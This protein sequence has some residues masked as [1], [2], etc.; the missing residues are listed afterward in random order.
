M[1][2]IGT[3]GYS[4]PDWKGSVYPKGIGPSSYLN[5]YE[6]ELGFNALE[7][8]F[9]YY[10]MPEHS[11]LKKIA[12][13]VSSDFMFSIKA[14]KSMTHEISESSNSPEPSNNNIKEYYKIFCDNAYALKNNNMPI[15]LFQ[16]PVSFKPSAE[17][18][19]YLSFMTEQVKPFQAAVEFRNRRWINEE[20][21][22]FLKQKELIYCAADE[23]NLP[24]LAPFVPQT[25]AASSYVRL[26]GRNPDWFSVKKEER[27]NY[28]Y[29]KEELSFFKEPVELMNK[30]SKT[31]FVFFNN[32]HGGKAAKNA[33][34]FRELMEIDFEPRQQRLF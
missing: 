14:N 8:N 10:R 24:S 5:Y 33:L 21:F 9:T 22:S 13:S 26:H 28:L 20:T 16:F 7:L 1:I 27:Y 17:T 23:P 18:I 15:I 3:S 19:D 32:C 30:L 31:V 6:N 25:T 11:Q 4:F 2:K 34:M 29:S 12:A